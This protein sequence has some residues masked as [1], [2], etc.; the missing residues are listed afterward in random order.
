MEVP[1]KKANTAI[2]GVCQRAGVNELP[3]AKAKTI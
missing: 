1:S 2:M 3:V